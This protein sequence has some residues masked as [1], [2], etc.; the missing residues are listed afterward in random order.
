MM[1]ENQLQK[2][3]SLKFLRSVTLYILQLTARDIEFKN[4]Y[5]QLKIK[6]NSYAH[7]GYLYFRGYR[8]EATVKSIK[9]LLK[10]GSTVIE[11]GGHIGFISHLY[12]SLVREKGKLIVFE[13]G[14]NNLNY[15]R[16]NLSMLKNT[17]L[18]EKACGNINGVLSF[19][20]DS[21]SGQ[22][23]SL[24]KDYENV[25]SVA[26]THGA[27]A[28]RIETKVDVIRL[29]DFISAEDIIVNHIKIDVEGAEK[30]VLL[31]LNSYLGK[32]P[33]FMI[34][35]TKNTEDIYSLMR[36]NCYLAYDDNLNLLSNGDLRTGNIFFVLHQQGIL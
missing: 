14:D 8:E 28:K 1:N 16:K 35:I 30:E 15:T 13:P 4:P 6:V 27:E 17:T 29:E 23:N 34:E 25:E 20:Q 2:I 36:A 10:D 18:V 11:V 22:N 32:I 31:G 26:R 24:L 9:R 19:Y 21:I 3:S 33:S 7:K 12:S 5:S